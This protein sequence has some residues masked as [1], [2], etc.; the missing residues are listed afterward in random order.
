[1]IPDEFSA[2]AMGFGPSVQ[3]K[4]AQASFDASKFIDLLSGREEGGVAVPSSFLDCGLLRDQIETFFG[5]LE[6]QAKTQIRPGH[7]RRRSRERAPRL[8]SRAPFL[9]PVLEASCGLRSPQ[10]E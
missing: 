1:M 10:I 5:W 3:S 8:M 7:P 4:P 2:L 6:E 9:A